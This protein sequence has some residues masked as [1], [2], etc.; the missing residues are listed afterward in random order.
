MVL[1]SLVGSFIPYV[2]Q[3]T[4]NVESTTSYLYLISA[5]V[6][7]AVAFMHIIPEAG[8]FIDDAAGGFP[9]S[10]CIMFFGMLLML[11]ISKVGDAEDAS[12]VSDVENEQIIDIVDLEP[13]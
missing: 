11:I 4:K 1:C 13:T 10:Y 8:S 7:S 9:V 2:M 5:G 12:D 6:L 3:K